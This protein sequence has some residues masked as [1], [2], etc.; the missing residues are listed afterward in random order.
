M[1]K[2]PTVSNPLEHVVSRIKI[3]LTG[4]SVMVLCFASISLIMCGV[5]ALELDKKIEFIAFVVPTSWIAFASAYFLIKLG[6]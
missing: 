5:S 3:T 6:N 1:K 2:Q 4:F